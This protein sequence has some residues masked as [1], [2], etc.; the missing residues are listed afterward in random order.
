MK[1]RMSMQAHPTF[2]IFTA[3]KTHQISGKAAFPATVITLI[4][5][6][7]AVPHTLVIAHSG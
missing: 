2:Q 4:Q 5:T 7:C 1:I 6:I 3:L